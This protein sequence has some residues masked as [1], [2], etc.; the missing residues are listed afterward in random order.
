MRYI[1]HERFKGKALGGYVNLARGTECEETNGLITRDGL[2]ICYK[3]SETGSKHFARNDDG[4]GL[5]RGDLT[6]QIIKLLRYEL[7]PDFATMRERWK[8]RAKSE[9]ERIYD[10]RWK[11]VWTDARFS[12][13]RRKE[14][15]DYWLWNADF[16]AASIDDLN[17][18]VRRL[19]DVKDIA[20]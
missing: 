19:T 11:I 13:Y 1:V 20:L 2:P 12:K 6:R 5:E 3:T 7:P 18:I 9:T 17:Y 8:T 10:A 15:A 4:R 16:Y 14:S